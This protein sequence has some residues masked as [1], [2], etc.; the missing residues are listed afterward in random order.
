LTRFC[1][2]PNSFQLDEKKLSQAVAD[3]LVK[4][5]QPKRPKTLNAVAQFKRDLIKGIDI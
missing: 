2:I 1:A 5:Q 3:I 4:K